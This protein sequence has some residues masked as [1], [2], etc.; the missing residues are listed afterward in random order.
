MSLREKFR[1]SE[2]ITAENFLIATKHLKDEVFCRVAELNSVR[3]YL[4]PVVTV[5]L[6]A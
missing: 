3:M 4:H 5:T 6:S 1:F 2:R